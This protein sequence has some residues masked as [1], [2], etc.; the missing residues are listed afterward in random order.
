MRPSATSGV[1]VAAALAIILSGCGSKHHDRTR[2]LRP[3]ARLAEQR[4]RRSRPP[5]SRPRSTAAGSQTGPNPTIADYSSRTTSRRPGQEGRPGS[6]DL[7]LRSRD[8]WE[9]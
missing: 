8:G 4:R 5:L 1:A 6:P 7:N 2:D 3:R 9:P